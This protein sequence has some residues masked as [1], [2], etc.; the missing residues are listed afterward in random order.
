MEIAIS[1]YVPITDDSSIGEAR[2]QGQLAAQRL[3][4][5]EVKVGEFALLATEVSRNVLRHAGGGH[6]IIFGCKNESGPVARILALDNGPGIADVM[7]AME[8]GYSTAGTMG[9]GLG[10]MRRIAG[11]LEIFTAS[12]GTIVFLELAENTPVNSLQ[13]AGLAVPYPGERVCGDAWTYRQDGDRTV[14]MLV[15]GLGHG[16][17]AAE[18]AQEAVSTFRKCGDRPPREIL[19]RLH[20]SL[21]KTRG[22]AAGIAEIRSSEKTITYAGVGNT[23]AVVLGTRVSRTFVSHNGTLGLAAPRIQEFRADWPE[24]GILVMHSDGLQSKWDLSSYSGLLARHSAVIAGALF[25]DFRRQ[26]D[27]ASVVVVKSVA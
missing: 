10:A 13:I 9:A 22:A 25:R 23:V 5:D 26:R 7:K 1:Q 17:Q 24:G 18:A 27:D 3:G 8:D 16:W 19:E 6:A 4:F 20:D 12:Q 15:D 2:R 14:L 11:S 21:K